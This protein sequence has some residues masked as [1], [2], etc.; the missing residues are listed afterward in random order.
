MLALADAIESHAD[1]LAELEA[2]DNGKPLKLAKRVDVPL[3]VEH[4]R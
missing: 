2:L 4:L 3:A 1:E